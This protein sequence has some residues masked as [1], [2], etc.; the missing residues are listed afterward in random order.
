[1]YYFFNF[2]VTLVHC[3]TADCTS[4]ASQRLLI[5]VLQYIASQTVIISHVSE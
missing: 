5:V 3:I 2:F 1:M 4:C